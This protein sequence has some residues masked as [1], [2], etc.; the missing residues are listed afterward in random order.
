MPTALIRPNS[1]QHLQS[2][3]Q[4]E[5]LLIKFR[6]VSYKRGRYGSH[7]PQ[8]LSSELQIQLPGKHAQWNNE[9]ANFNPPTATVH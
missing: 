6:L 3:S 5:A 8:V 7:E 9:E 4:Y 2:V 1:L